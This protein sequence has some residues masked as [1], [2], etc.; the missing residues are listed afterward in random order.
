MNDTRLANATAADLQQI[1]DAIAHWERWAAKQ[2]LVLP[3][4]AE[5]QWIAALKRTR[6]RIKQQPTSPASA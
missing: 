1:E 2:F 5:S 6:D 3:E 4:S